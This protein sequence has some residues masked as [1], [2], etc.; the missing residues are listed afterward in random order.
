M[1]RVGLGARLAAVARY[2]PPGSMVADVG[3]GDGSLAVYL[4][5]VRRCRVIAT[6]ASRAALALTAR[7]AATCG[8]A[9]ELRYGRG[10]GPLRPG[11]AGIIIIAGMGGI[12][13]S[14]VLG[15]RPSGISPRYFVLQPAARAAYLRC[16]LYARGWKVLDED[17]VR[18]GKRFYEILV[19]RPENGET[20]AKRPAGQGE[21]PLAQGEVGRVLWEKRHPLLRPFLEQKIAGYRAVLAQA[22]R[23]AGPRAAAARARAAA[24]LTELEALAATCDGGIRGPR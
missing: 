13:I 12:A 18:E 19:A 16:W 9:L 10:L 14:R 5:T 3:C 21:A 8:A 1:T 7:R 17:L 6:E 11:E 20:A 22:E 4:A 15:G 23:G 2:V 24:V